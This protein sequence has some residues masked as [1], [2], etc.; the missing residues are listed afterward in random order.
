MISYNDKTELVL[1]F[2]II[3]ATFD[4]DN[5]NCPIAKFGIVENE[6]DDLTYSIGKSAI[7]MESTNSENSTIKFDFSKIY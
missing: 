6:Q 4:S 2:L 7:V 5:K 3:N 1:D